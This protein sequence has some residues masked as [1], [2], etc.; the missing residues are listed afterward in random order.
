[1]ELSGYVIGFKQASQ[2][3]DGLTPLHNYDREELGNLSV[4]SRCGECWLYGLD[5]ALSICYLCY[6]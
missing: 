3:S 5:G 2:S 6:V 4:I 1:M